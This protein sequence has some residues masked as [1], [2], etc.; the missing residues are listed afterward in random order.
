LAAI[1]QQILEEV[2][3]PKR[4]VEKAV[5]RKTLVLRQMEYQGR[6]DLLKERDQLLKKYQA[7]FDSTLDKIAKQQLAE[8]GLSYQPSLL[9]PR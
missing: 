6:V 7:I 4:H 2:V 9:R 1:Q 5:Q 3:K 8:G